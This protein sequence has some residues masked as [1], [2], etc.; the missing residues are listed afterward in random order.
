MS[1]FDTPNY[2]EYSYSVKNEGKIRLYRR[3]MCIG[4]AAF[5][6]IFFSVCFA[7]KLVPIGA[8]Y[9]IFMWIIYF[10]TWR[11]VSFDYYFVFQGGNLELGTSRN[12]K[13]GMRKYERLKI[14][15]KEALLI[16]PLAGNEDAAKDAKI[17]DFS[18]SQSSDKRILL[19]FDNKGEKSAAIFEG[20]KKVAKLLA[21][22]CANAEG[23]KNQD[24]HG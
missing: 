9:P 12:S 5:T 1:E 10:F 7:T 15:V 23:L 22:F 14:H 16:A 18:E 8:T 13:Q 20:T 3:L 24:F 2:A 21:S 11:Y 17:Y 19:V 6:V 4:Y